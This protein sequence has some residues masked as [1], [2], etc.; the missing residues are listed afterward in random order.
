MAAMGVEEVLAMN[1]SIKS[2]MTDFR[3]R[4][5]AWSGAQVERLEGLKQSQDLAV[6]ECEGKLEPLMDRKLALEAKVERV[7]QD[8]KVARH[9][10]Q[11][12]QDELDTLKEKSSA[13]PAEVPPPPASWVRGRSP[14][15]ASGRSPCRSPS[16]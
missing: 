1:A 12:M 16:R 13:M 6:R 4:F 3:S 9:E 15:R 14:W 7:E 5:D 8:G 2:S 11:A 10:V